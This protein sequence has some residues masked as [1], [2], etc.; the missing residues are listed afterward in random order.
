M[1]D[2]DHDLA[3]AA[4]FKADP[5]YAAALLSSVEAD[6]PPE[7]WAIIRRQMQLARMTPEGQQ[8]GA[9]AKKAQI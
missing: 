2:R 8:Q 1:P 6:G 5:A 7:E 4:V 9:E 3:M